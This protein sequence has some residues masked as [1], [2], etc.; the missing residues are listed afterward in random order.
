MQLLHQSGYKVIAI[1]SAKNH[2][3]LVELGAAVC[4]DYKEKN[5]VENIRQAAGE[6]GIY[7]AYDT[8]ASAGSTDACIGKLLEC[9]QGFVSSNLMP[10]GW[11]R[12]Y[13]ASRRRGDVY[14]S[15][16]ERVRQT[17]IGR[18][19]RILSGL[20]VD[21]VRSMCRIFIQ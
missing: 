15:S 5:V 7:A 16:F 8:A 11:F 1:A 3:R 14:A 19:R 9:S 6:K 2:R 21:G 4:F 10:F 17:P 18:G 20:Y 12:C 13:G